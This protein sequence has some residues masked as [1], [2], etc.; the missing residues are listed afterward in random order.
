MKKTAAAALA[1]TFVPSAGKSAGAQTAPQV[2][3]PDAPLTW[4]NWSGSISCTPQRIERPSTEGE[5][6]SL[7]RTAR[8]EN[9]VVRLVGSGHSFVPLC[10]TEGM[11]MSLANMKGVISTE[12]ERAEATVWSGTK[13]RHM[14]EP[15]RAAGL[16][17]EN[18]SDI[19]R[20]AIAGAIATATHGTGH[21]IRNLSSQVIGIRF[22]TAAGDIVDCSKD[23]QPEIFKAAQVSLGALGIL[24]QV[25]MQLVPTFR[26]HEKVWNASF[27]ECFENMAG[28]IRDNRHFEFFWLPGSDTCIIKTLNPTDRM[29]DDLPDVEGERIG[30]SDQ[31]FPSVRSRR[32]NEI[33]FSLSEEKGPDCLVELRQLM[34]TRHTEIAMPL[35]Y[36]TV[37]ADDI[38]LSPAYG[39][40]TVTIS[41]H[42]V[43]NAQYEK[44]FG[45]VEAVF[46]NHGG[47]PHWGKIH[48]FEAAELAELYP[49]W[50]KFQDVR[51]E[52]DPGGRFMNAHLRGILS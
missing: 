39:R 34:L 11:L 27:D 14:G 35:E 5:V 30:H 3:R 13:I 47:R 52:L 8:A 18:I 45:D 33:E 19:D 43:A 15:L 24:T 40:D 32:F 37:G 4:K 28:T 2:E 36:R 20:Q 29:P 17:M 44:F 7:L 16:A 10:A 22:V 42:R 6:R 46:R 23:Q 21:G 48:T 12:T 38:Y 1:G 49:M 9:L 41:A 25:R 26:L 51:T 31:I 50:E